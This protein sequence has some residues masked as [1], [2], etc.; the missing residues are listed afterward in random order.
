V[1][2]FIPNG[3]AAAEALELFIVDNGV[4]P[5]LGNLDGPCAR[6]ESFD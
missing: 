6:Q 3:L 1:A 5:A 4:A 2:E